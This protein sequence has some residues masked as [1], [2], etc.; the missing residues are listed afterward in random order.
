MHMLKLVL[1]L[2]GVLMANQ[3]L[4]HKASQPMPGVTA[5]TG[6]TLAKVRFQP[7]APLDSPG[8]RSAQAMSAMPAA[9]LRAVIGKKHTYTHSH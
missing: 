5:P 1:P 9:A 8:G 2:A 7:G 3:A 6:S 4:A